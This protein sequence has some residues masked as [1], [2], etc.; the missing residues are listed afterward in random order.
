MRTVTG[1]QASSTGLCTSD[2][3]DVRLSVGEASH[4]VRVRLRLRL[5][6]WGV[7]VRVRVRVKGG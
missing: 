3:A 1:K 4:L 5:T 7:R 6:G 2:P